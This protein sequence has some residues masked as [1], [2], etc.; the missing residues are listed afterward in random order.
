MKCNKIVFKI[1]IELLKIFK[2][3]LFFSILYKG[4]IDEHFL[5]NAKKK[6]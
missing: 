6:I 5:N 1:V 2:M 3:L 4:K